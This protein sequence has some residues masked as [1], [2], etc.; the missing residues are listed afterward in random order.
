MRSGPRPSRA[1]RRDSEPA[2]AHPNASIRTAALPCLA[3]LSSGR[4]ARM[5]QRDASKGAAVKRASV[6]ECARPSG[7]VAQRKSCQAAGE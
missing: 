2:V 4:N 5:S 1:L 7:A 6:L 3:Q